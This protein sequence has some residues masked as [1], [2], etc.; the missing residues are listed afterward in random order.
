MGVGMQIVCVGFTGS[1]AL[2]AEA[3]AQLVRL[4]RFRA[5]LDDCR[6]TIE[7]RAIGE[8]DRTYDVRL[9]LVMHDRAP[10]SLPCSTGDDM[11]E[12]LRRAFAQAEQAL[13][14]WQADEPEAVASRA[15]A[16]GAAAQ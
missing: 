3:G 10:A 6:L 13:S 4:E 9:E 14:A 12:T 7:S 8:G 11:N 16:T 1:A 2:E 15:V 5:R